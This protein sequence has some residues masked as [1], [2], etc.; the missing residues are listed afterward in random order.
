M[1][2][3]KKQPEPEF[4]FEVIPARE[5]SPREAT[6]LLVMGPPKTGKSHFLASMAEEGPTLLIATLE[7]ETSSEGYQRWNP[8]TI[9]LDD[10]GWRP[11]QGRFETKGFQRFLDLVDELAEDEEYKVILLD[12]GTELG[13]FAWHEALRPFGVASPGDMDDR[14]NRFR[15]YTKIADLMRQALDGLLALKTA[16]VPKH[17]VVAWHI[18]PTK[19]DTVAYDKTTQSHAKKLSGD[20]R[21]EGVEY[22]GS[23]LPTMPGG[24]RRRVAG[25]FDGVVYTDKLYER[26]KGKGG[27]VLKDKRPRYV[28]Q[29]IPDEERDASIPGLTPPEM[30]I[31]NEWS[32]LKPLLGEEG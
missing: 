4:E 29:V 18:Q 23:V 24:F 10:Y 16:P 21:G 8:D 31:D 28:I 26:K 7:R 19:D 3:R 6:S 32:A 17:V 30:Y 5:L 25:L 13:E 14:D 11:S 2:A 27:R 22:G 1:P 12:N 9:L 20:T 15:P